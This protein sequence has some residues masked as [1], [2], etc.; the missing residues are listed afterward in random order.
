V[1]KV[2]KSLL[3]NI[4]K[5][6]I[7]EVFEAKHIINKQEL[8]AEYPILNEPL[9][10]FI[11]LY[12][13]NELCGSSGSFKTTRSLLEDIIHHSKKAA[14]QDKEFQPL[15]VS[16]YLITT[17]ELSLLTPST[18][19]PFKDIQELKEKITPFEDGVTLSCQENTTSFLPMQ[20]SL[21]PN[22]ELF[23][24]ALL[25]QLGVSKLTNEMK[26]STFQVQ[27]QK[28]EPIIS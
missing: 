10:S 22:F 20:W 26:V 12:I 14:F 24:S 28:N 3:L 17:I 6:S 27:K 2:S 9:A 19:I 1:V 25:K 7:T 21:Y 4:A 15:K 18:D 23:L 16:Q 5:D 11:H 13:D 8:L